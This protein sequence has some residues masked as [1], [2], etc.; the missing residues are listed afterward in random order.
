MKKTARLLDW[1]V[2]IGLFLGYLILTHSI[3]LFAILTTFAIITA[4][5][6]DVILLPIPILWLISTILG[7]KI[8]ISG[9]NK[10]LDGDFNPVNVYV[11]FFT[12]VIISCFLMRWHFIK[13]K[14]KGTF[15]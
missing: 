13:M 9:S 3:L 7:F 11:Y 10:G 1:L 8:L 5:R 14:K 4:G 2:Q 6:E 15:K 12:I